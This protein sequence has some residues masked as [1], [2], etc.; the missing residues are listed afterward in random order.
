VM[1][2]GSNA[3]ASWKGTRPDWLRDHKIII[4]VQIGLQK[5]DDLPDVPLMM[6]LGKTPEDRAALKLLSAATEIGRPLFSTPDVP[7]DRVTAL[8]KAF[9]DTMKDPKFIADAEQA[10]LDLDPVSGVRLQEVVAE[11]LATPK[12]VVTRLAAALEERDVVK[13]LPEPS[14]G[15]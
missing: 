9:D 15:R 14:G 2:R 1:G 10:K 3:W 6:N 13:G 11:M 7:K 4:L 5:A 8:R 12:P